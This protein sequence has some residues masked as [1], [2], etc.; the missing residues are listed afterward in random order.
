MCTSGIFSG[1]CAAPLTFRKQRQG[2][3]SCR[4]GNN[5]QRHSVCRR[6]FRTFSIHD[7]ADLRKGVETIILMQTNASRVYI[8]DV[9]VLRGET[10]CHSQAC[11]C[12]CWETR[13]DRKQFQYIFR[14]KQIN[15]TP[16]IYYQTNFEST[17]HHPDVKDCPGSGSGSGIT[18]VVIDRHVLSPQTCE[19]GDLKIR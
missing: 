14:R 13:Q 9:E 6:I 19:T 3:G 5:Y 2:D 15:A 10:A 8:I 12:R 11:I 17:S 4:V 1:L 16:D 18:L 7:S